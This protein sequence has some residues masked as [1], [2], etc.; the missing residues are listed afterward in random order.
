MKKPWRE[1]LCFI[2]GYRK[3]HTRATEVNIH[4]VNSRGVGNRS[5]P[6]VNHWNTLVAVMKWQWWR[7]KWRRC[8]V[9]IFQTRIC[10][11]DSYV[12]KKQTNYRVIFLRAACSTGSR[13]ICL[14]TLHGFKSQKNQRRSHSIGQKPQRVVDQTSGGSAQRLKTRRSDYSS[15]QIISPCGYS[16]VS[17]IPKN[18]SATATGFFF[19]SH[20]GLTS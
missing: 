8:F 11:L 7:K 3:H 18:I 5:S 2:K 10:R 4:T 17:F 1:H 6:I 20:I 16:V 12:W 13:M 19:S 15:Y 14:R 9:A